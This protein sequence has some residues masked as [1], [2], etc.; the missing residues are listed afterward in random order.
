L[1]R[2]WD[3]YVL[4]VAFAAVVGVFGFV[5]Q[6]PSLTWAGRPT[7]F[8]DD[9]DMLGGFLLPGVLASLY[10]IAEKRRRLLFTAA[11]MLLSVTLILSFSRGAIVSGLVWGGAAFL[12]FNRRNLLKASV[13]AIAVLTFLGLACVVL[14]LANDSFA[15]MIVGRF[16]L[17][18]PYDLG[19]LGRY[20][21]YLL[22]IPMILDNP[23][24]IGILQEFKYF[25]EPNHNI[26]I[27]AFLDYGWT[28]GLAWTLLMVLSIQQTWYS[29]K[30]SRNGLS[31]LI[32]LSWLS[33][34]SCAMLQEADRWRFMWM[35]T[36]ML[37][38]L[39][40]SDRGGVAVDGGRVSGR[41]PAAGQERP[42]LGEYASV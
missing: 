34:V 12:F 10:M 39:N 28:A 9:P 17:A 5:T 3:V 11:L 37:W 7:G 14:Y 23:F 6:N 30:R 29:W 18:E 31:L 35:L 32:L 4:A 26:W 21:R 33:V 24:G 36:G 15:E 20:N 40:Y 38:G 41:R 1:L 22:A 27:T 19:H 13:A 2:F 25:P 8:L 16:S 42:L